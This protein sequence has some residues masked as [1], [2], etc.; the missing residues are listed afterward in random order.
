[1]LGSEAMRTHRKARARRA[2]TF[3]M[4]LEIVGIIL[5]RGEHGMDRMHAEATQRA[6]GHIAGE[7]LEQAEIAV[8]AEIADAPSQRARAPPHTHPAGNALAAGF[9]R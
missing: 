8:G 3:Q 6:I 1:M 2:A 7:F 9:P 5:H 4:R